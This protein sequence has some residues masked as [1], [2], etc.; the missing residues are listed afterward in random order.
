MASKPSVRPLVLPSYA[1]IAQILLGVCLTIALLYVGQYVFIPIVFSALFAILL[2]PG[3][4]WLE[5]R[6]VPRVV[7][8]SIAVVLLVLVVSAVCYFTVLES[9]FLVQD[10]PQFTKKID[11]MLTDVENYVSHHFSVSPKKQVDWVKEQLSSAGGFALF[12]VMAVGNFIQQATLVLVYIFLF[13]YY[14]GL[15]SNFVVHL[16]PSGERETVIDI[17]S[18]VGTVVNRYLIGK[19][20]ETAI[21]VVL[22]TGG[23]MLLGIEQ[24]LLFGL[25]AGLLNLIPFIGVFIGSALPAIMALLTKDSI[26]YAVGVVGLFIVV[27]FI[28]NHVIVP[29]LIGGQ[30]RVNAVA[31]IVAL[32][33]GGE[34]WGVSGL[35]LSLPV[36]AILKIVC[37]QVESLHPWGILLGIPARKKQ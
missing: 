3:T 30:I 16:F 35:I 20:I 5:Q 29:V 37:D 21:L 31:T 32:I 36:V 6:K 25:L 18:R 2:T 1:K 22:T 4:D 19:A 10:V 9:S 8:I 34:L 11:A 15:F 13:L 24:A 17:L 23:L 14:R 26:W 7:A 33:A 12:T 27:Q 28:D